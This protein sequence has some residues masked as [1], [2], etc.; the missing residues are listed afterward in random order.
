MSSLGMRRSIFV[1]T[2]PLLTFLLAKALFYMSWTAPTCTREKST[3]RLKMKHV[4][5][6]CVPFSSSRVGS[7][8]IYVYFQGC[9]QDSLPRWIHWS[10][11]VRSVLTVGLLET[12]LQL[13]VPTAGIS[14]E[15]ETQWAYAPYMS[16]DRSAY[17]PKVNLIH[18][19]R[20]LRIQRQ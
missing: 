12:M 10:R 20:I 11:C 15:T 16:C 19:Q 1:H 5:M 7:K 8:L 9:G 17:G 3:K 14:G 2:Y 6:L 4:A 18:P 13:R